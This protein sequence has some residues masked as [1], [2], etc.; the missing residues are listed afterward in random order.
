MDH[1][2]LKDILEP[3]SDPVPG[4]FVAEIARKFNVLTMSRPAS[5]PSHHGQRRDDKRRRSLEEQ[6]DVRYCQQR[7]RFES[8][9]P[10]L[11]AT[12][13]LSHETPVVAG[14]FAS[15]DPDASQADF[16]PSQG[17]HSVPRRA[18]RSPAS[19]QRRAFEQGTPH[20]AWSSPTTPQ[21]TSVRDSILHPRPRHPFSSLRML[22]DE[23]SFPLTAPST[24]MGVM[25]QSDN[26]G[27]S[28]SPL[29]LNQTAHQCPQSAEDTHG[30]T[31]AG[32]QRS[33]VTMAEVVNQ[34]SLFN[35]VGSAIP[36]YC[37]EGGWSSQTLWNTP[38]MLAAF[39]HYNTSHAAC[40]QHRQ[41]TQQLVNLQS[42]SGQY[43]ESQKFWELSRQLHPSN[44]ANVPYPA[45]DI[46]FYSQ[47]QQQ[48]QQP[49]QLSTDAIR[50]SMSG[51]M[52]FPALRSSMD[53][54]A[55]VHRSGRAPSARQERGSFAASD[56]SG[57]SLPQFQQHPP[58]VDS[59]DTLMP[60][61]ELPAM[62]GSSSS[63]GNF[64]TAPSSSSLEHMASSLQA[65]GDNSSGGF[66]RLSR[67]G[68]V[69]DP[70]PKYCDNCHT[71]STPSWRRCPQGQILLCNACGLYQKLHGRPRPFFKT[72]DGAIKIHRT[73]PEHPPC[74]K[75]GTRSTTTWRKD[76]N[77][78][79]I[80]N[81]CMMTGK[82]A[83]KDS[84]GTCDGGSPPSTKE[85]PQAASHPEP[86]T[87]GAMMA[88]PGQT[89]GSTSSV[90]GMLA[91]GGSA[92]RRA[93]R[94]RARSMTDRSSTAVSKSKVARARPSKANSAAAMCHTSSQYSFDSNEL[95]HVHNGLLSVPLPHGFASSSLR[96]PMEWQQHQR[97]EGAAY[98]F[99]S[100]ENGSNPW[101]THGLVVGTSST[102]GFDFEQTPSSESTARQMMT[103]P[104]PPQGY[105]AAL[106]PLQQQLGSITSSFATEWS[107][108]T[109]TTTASSGDHVQ[110]HQQPQSYHPSQEVH[111][112]FSSYVLYRQQQQQ[113][114][115]YQ[116]EQQQRYQQE[117]QRYQQRRQQQQQQQQQQPQQQPPPQIYRYPQERLPLAPHHPQCQE[118]HDSY[119]DCQQPYLPTCLHQHLPPQPPQ[120]QALPGI[121]EDLQSFL[122]DPSQSVSVNQVPSPSISISNAIQED[123]RS[124]G[125]KARS[126]NSN[127]DNSS[128]INGSNNDPLAMEV[129]E[130]AECTSH[131][132][133]YPSA[134]PD[135]ALVSGTSEKS[136]L[137]PGGDGGNNGGD[138]GTPP[139]LQ[140]PSF[141]LSV[142]TGSAAE[143]RASVAAETRPIPPD[144]EM[145]S[146][147]WPDES[148]AEQAELHLARERPVPKQEPPPPKGDED[149][150]KDE[151]EK[152]EGEREEEE[153]NDDIL[154][155]HSYRLARSHPSGST[156]TVSDTRSH[157][158][159]GVIR[160]VVEIPDLRL[161]RSDRRRAPSHSASKGC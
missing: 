18:Y 102:A 12:G 118:H 48:Q 134:I 63:N 135:L 155:R 149:K 104:P 157:Y 59:A 110:Q 100:M 150:V 54:F 129:V 60:M 91:A 66:T 145:T 136:P 15:Q 97:Q 2:K 82:Q 50:H 52:P 36:S 96:Y 153:E 115:Q 105:E 43:A 56:G 78:R 154:R 68:L 120:A 3:P 88:L 58:F 76:E 123:S 57:S 124:S 25:P 27:R 89:A 128:N 69:R 119:C 20:E 139:L 67:Q 131:Y 26:P 47:Q 90:R 5:A 147:T 144:M 140:D 138:D 62:G 19:N 31:S 132:Y 94:P 142:P 21:P 32:Y 34:D 39:P 29:A 70:D 9:P 46:S 17:I 121:S 44:P 116:Q 133:Y 74:V 126:S 113:Q 30:L 148:M 22:S 6:S 159:R 103:Y 143:D 53:S 71:T 109:A 42:P 72:K 117:H 87:T 65:Q 111:S 4:P 83:H 98:S 28:P 37:S 92:G 45:Q 125:G 10:T 16:T 93:S 41:A 77:N 55:G 40:Q 81:V 75:C 23:A 73:V 80:C 156:S 86:T 24:P 141:E 152:E 33:S 158:A 106:A 130:L 84:R 161:R 14:S 38:Y 127:R 13:A 1:S 85:D 61:L 8:E 51:F 99:Q 146:N 122:H 137:L 79:T 107:A 112:Q 108:Q 101:L 160:A 35:N 151:G 64:P 49:Q 114:Q 11:D 7:R 95:P